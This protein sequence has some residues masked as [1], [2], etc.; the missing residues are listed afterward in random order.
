VFLS[1]A[2]R[3]NST[4]VVATDGKTQR[5][6]ASSSE[7]AFVF[8]TRDQTASVEAVSVRVD[9]EAEGRSMFRVRM[10]DKD[11]ITS[12]QQVKVLQHFSTALGLTPDGPQRI[13][14]DTDRG[15]WKLLGKHSKHGLTEARLDA[16]VTP[17]GFAAARAK[18]DDDAWAAAARFHGD[19]AGAKPPWADGAGAP[20]VRAD[21]DRYIEL[22]S[23]PGE[24][25]EHASELQWI[26]NTY[27]NAHGKSIWEDVESYQHARSFTRMIGEMRGTADPVQWNKSFADHGHAVGFRAFE[28]VGVLA[29]LVGREHVVVHQFAVE[30]KAVQLKFKEADAPADPR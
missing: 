13:E 23:S 19:T 20:S 29:N 4:R 17:Q 30:G 10:R 22:T 28:S 8:G 3:S 7:R 25:S 5:T 12:E 26:E 15:A 24:R 14:E 16:Y 27:R 18:T 1:E 9:G 11:R 21:L 2:L 6:D